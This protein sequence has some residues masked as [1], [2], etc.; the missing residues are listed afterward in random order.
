MNN[1][2]AFYTSINDVHKKG[3][4][5]RHLYKT[6][7][8]IISADTLEEA[9]EKAKEKCN[10]ELILEDV[11]RINKKQLKNIFKFYK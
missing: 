11:I 3:Y 1:Y 10:R 8:L 7:P 9:I 4:I 6:I 2:A 5:Y